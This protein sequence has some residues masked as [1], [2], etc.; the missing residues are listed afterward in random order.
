MKRKNGILG[1]FA[2]LLFV[3]AFAP[4]VYAQSEPG[5]DTEGIGLSEVTMGSI[6]PVVTETG[7]IS[8]SV[9]GLGVYPGNS[10][11][12]Q[13]EKPAGATVRSA[14]MAA[15]TTGF[16]NYRL[17]D[18]DIMIDGVGIA[19]DIETRSSISSWNY[20]ADVTS[21]VK[22]KIDAAPAG[23]VDFTITEKNTYGIDGEILA[24]IFDDPNQTTDNTIVLL[25]GAQ[26]V[27][28]DTFAIGLAEPIDTSDP[29]L[30]LD[31]SLGISY[32]YQRYGGGQY[33]IVDVNGVRLTT[34]AG[35]EDDGDH[36]NGALL[37]VGGLDDS[38]ANPPD[39]YAT[40][41]NPRTDDELYNLI[42]FVSDGDTSIHVYTR[43][44]SNDDNIFFAALFLASTTAV[45]GEGILLA[46]VSASNPVGSEHT[47]TA[48]VQD[49]LGNPIVGRDV[50]FTIVSGPHAGLSYIDTTDANG[51]ATFTYTGTS[52]GTDV[53]EATMVDSQGNTVTSN[54]VTKEW[55]V[56]ETYL[57]PD[58][59]RWSIHHTP[60]YEWDPF[61]TLFRSWT[62]VYFVNSGPGDAYNVTATITCAP[63]NVNIVDGDVT[64]G[65]IPAGSGAWSQDFFM[66]EVDMTNPQDPNKGIVWRVEYDDAA[67][68]HHVIENI[69]TFCGEP[70]NCP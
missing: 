8:L 56:T 18:G 59:Y 38:N 9:D 51:Q 41:S 14:Y 68:N 47:V 70:I 28:G 20:W 48:T 62:D 58:E 53:I 52:A 32:G 45:V 31:M 39:P 4:Q 13:V 67:G 43:N 27:A 21:I 64:L 63:V 42:P 10:G 54:Q 49:D 50:T 40:P 60:P 25:F 1:I 11:T 37:T 6:V 44:P 16:T 26:D 30:V 35:G 23:R 2:I 34:S 61:P 7:K 57:C 3:L 69:P 22:S 66:L 15:A 36:S 12:I 19:W 24:V 65:D 55:T 46:P 29:N 33:S 5:V 17:A